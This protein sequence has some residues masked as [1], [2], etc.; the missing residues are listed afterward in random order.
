M[1]LKDYVKSCQN[2]E[3]LFNPSIMRSTVKKV[4]DLITQIEKRSEEPEL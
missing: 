2:K 1:K 3:V 4:S